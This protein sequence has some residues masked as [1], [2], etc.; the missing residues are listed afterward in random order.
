[1]GYIYKITNKINEKV[2]IGLTTLTVNDRWKGHLDSARR[3]NQKPLYCAIRKY[4]IENF[5]IEEIDRT[6]DFAK[7]GELERKYIEQYKSYDKHYGYNLTRGGEHNQLDANPRTRLTV[8]DV[9]NIRQIYNECKIG[10]KECWQM[11]KDRISYDAFEKIYEGSTWKTIMPEVYNEEKKSRHKKCLKGQ[12]G[13]KNGNAVLSDAEVIKIRKYYMNH[14]LR[15]C[16]EKYGQKYKTK[17]AFR[18]IIDSS[19]L[20]IPYYLKIKK[21]WRFNGKEYDTFDEIDY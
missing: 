7:L 16:Y 19:Y 3:N 11:Y 14:T 13:E 20:H 10:C 1:M 17:Q 12:K 5:K 18:G 6:E 15:E 4:G 2:Y 21:K 8:K 9:E